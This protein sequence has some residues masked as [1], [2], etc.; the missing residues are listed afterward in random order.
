M[1]KQYQGLRLIGLILK[2]AGGLEMALG[3]ISLVLIP[4]VIT[5][6]DGALSQFG[7]TSPSPG[8]ALGIGIIAGIVILFVGVVAG[9]LTF[10]LGELINVV[11]A[12]EENTRSI[13]HN[14]NVPPG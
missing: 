7:W 4:L 8:A 14:T 11:I 9:L 10:A 5:G 3:V 13:A 6:A 12:I 1:I 2:I